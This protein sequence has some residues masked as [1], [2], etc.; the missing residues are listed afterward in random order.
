[1]SSVE[2]PVTDRRLRAEDFRSDAFRRDALQRERPEDEMSA[3]GSVN[4]QQLEEQL[5]RGP[6]DEIAALMRALTYGQM[7]ELAEGCGTLTGRRQ[8]SQRTPYPD[9]CIAGQ[10]LVLLD[11]KPFIAVPAG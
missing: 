10:R 3:G 7:M 11:G 2:L 8:K 4:L 1:M 9:Y 6:V 5:A